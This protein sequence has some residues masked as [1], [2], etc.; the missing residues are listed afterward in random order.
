MCPKIQIEHEFLGSLANTDIKEFGWILLC[1]LVT[2]V[3]PPP[4]HQR[5]ILR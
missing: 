5:H 1:C 4:L 3:P 2:V